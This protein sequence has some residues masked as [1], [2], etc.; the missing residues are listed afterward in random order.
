MIRRKFRKAAMTKYS[1]T[2]EF[3]NGRAEAGPPADSE[4]VVR[5]KR[6]QRWE[7][8]DSH[9]LRLGEAAVLRTWAVEVP[10]PVF[11]CP[12]VVALWLV[13]AHADPRA[14]LGPGHGADVR[15]LPSPA[16]RLDLAAAAQR[17]PLQH[18]LQG[19]PLLLLGLR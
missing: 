1:P 14:P 16:A 8:A 3:C 9:V 15:D 5:G 4:L 6:V 2:R 13:E 18:R 10:R 19:L 7:V 17:D 11:A 12:V